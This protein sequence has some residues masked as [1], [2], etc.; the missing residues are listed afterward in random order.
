MQSMAQAILAR[1]FAPSFKE[2]SP[3]AYNGY[4][5][6]L[7]RA[8]VEGY[9]GTCEAIR[10]ADLTEAASAVEADALVLC[11]TQ[12]LSTPPGSVQELAGLMPN[13]GFKLISDAGH[14]ACIEQPDALAEQIQ[15]FLRA[16]LS[17][18]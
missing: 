5:N 11:G 13:A 18:S 9:T 2:K 7:T 8:A 1:W 6:M 17:R 4:Y 15:Q 3:A 16:P 12:D 10:D 14:L